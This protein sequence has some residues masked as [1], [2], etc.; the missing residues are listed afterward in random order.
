ML[1]PLIP[2]KPLIQFSFEALTLEKILLVFSDF[3]MFI[4]HGMREY[5]FNIS[6]LLWYLLV[7]PTN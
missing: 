6:T 7:K 3:I 4:T 5:L 2:K 1:T